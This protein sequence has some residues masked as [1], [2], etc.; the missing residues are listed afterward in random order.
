MHIEYDMEKRKLF[1]LWAHASTCFDNCIRACQEI[2]RLCSSENSQL[3][4]AL[5]HYAII[6]YAKPFKW[7]R[8]IGKLPDEAKPKSSLKRHEHTVDIRDKIFAHIDC[9]YVD[10]DEVFN[11]V[12]IEVLSN[13]V[14]YLVADTRISMT[15]TAS[16]RE[17]AEE[18]FKKSRYHASRH[19]ADLSGKGR[20]LS[21]GVYKV[22]LTSEAD[23]A[24]TRIMNSQD[25]EIE[26]I[27]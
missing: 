8:G 13:R 27:E 15:A 9:D 2:E 18:M 5:S 12:R 7:N 10:S 11:P 14:D 1:V 26:W 22:N 20:R 4:K 16:L 6:E 24:L 21:R 19:V 3:F 25:S 17:L 23:S